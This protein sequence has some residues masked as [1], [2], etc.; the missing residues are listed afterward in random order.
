[1]EEQPQPG[2]SAGT[3]GAADP[4]QEEPYRLRVLMEPKGFIRIIE[5]VLAVLMF[6]TT[7]GYNGIYSY[8]VT[9][10][11]YLHQMKYMFGYPFDFKSFPIFCEP[12]TSVTEIPIPAYVGGK[13]SFFVA[14]GVLA[15][16]YCILSLVW[17]VFLEVRYLTF[18]LVPAADF[19]TT[20]VFSV[21][22][23]LSACIWASGVSTVKYWTTFDNVK[24][25]LLTIPCNTAGNTCEQQSFP[26]YASINISV[27]FGFL[28]CVVWAG[29]GWFVFKET[30]WFKNRQAQNQQT[31]AQDK[32]VN[33]V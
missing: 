14:I 16:I 17:Y 9:C 26:N 18:D 4:K 23:F 10:T 1:M 25:E 27:V 5:F 13:A 11:G 6:A 3:T 2:S 15:M 8:N 31:T 12:N 33:T 32:P 20:V 22:F 19:V 28:N 24:K 29:N 21:F 30:M 7:A